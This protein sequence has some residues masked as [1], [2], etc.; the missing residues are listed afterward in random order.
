MHIGGG[1]PFLRF[2][3]LLETVRVF[4]DEGIQLDYL[5]TNASWFTEKASAIEK[6]SRLAEAGCDTVMVSICPFH[7]EFIPL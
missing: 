2:R 5:E 6:L 7:V 3:E 1:E 4:R